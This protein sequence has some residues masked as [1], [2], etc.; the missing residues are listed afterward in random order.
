[1]NPENTF[2]NKKLNKPSYRKKIFVLL[3][4]VSGSKAAQFVHYFLM[5]LILITVIA[6]I[7]ESDEEIYL[8]YK[9][10]FWYLEI[11]SLIIFSLEYILRVWVSAENKSYKGFKGRIKYMLTPMAIIDLLAVLPAWFG[12]F[13][14]RDFMI[15]RGLRLIRVFKLTRYSRSMN[16]LMLVLK[17]ESSNI[18]SAF[19]VL[20]I[21]IIIAATGMH[22]VEGDTQD[23]F[24]TIPKAIW[25][26][27]VTLTTVGYGD[28]VPITVP[29]KVFGII[30]LI[31]GIGMAALPAGI[32]ASGYTEEINRRRERFKNQV[33]YFFADGVLDKHET[34]KLK[35]LAYELGI[36]HQDM[37]SIIWEI[38]QMQLKITEIHCP[39]C[40]KPVEIEHFSKHIKVKR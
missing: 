22:I 20:M 32:L 30:I 28:V 21:L 39:H 11:F 14:S 13:V 25:W 18:F 2:I 16:L 9:V 12:L 3:E 7:L 29:G 27:T 31:S 6:V 19:F 17:Q 5:I 1:M 40:D 37:K 15:L 36:P 26:A 23:A 24:G 34:K 33:M 4:N 38:K 8:K 10:F 35:Q